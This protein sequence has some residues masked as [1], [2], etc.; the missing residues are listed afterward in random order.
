MERYESAIAAEEAGD[1]V[2]LAEALRRLAILRH[3]RSDSPKARELC[4]R[5][6]E[7]AGKIGNEVLAAEAL[8]TLGGVELSTGALQEARRTFLRALQLGRSS[9]EVRAR[10][11]QNLGILAN[12]QGDLHEALTRY[13]RSLEAYRQCGDEH[14][15]AIAYHNMGSCLAIP[16]SA[17]AQVRGFPKRNAG[18]SRSAA[19]IGSWE[20]SVW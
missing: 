6:Y 9:R 19:A 18:R 17:Y 2:V 11:E 14:G 8:N 16:A 3:H 4:R 10:V 5:S 1:Q 20:R 15:R 12:I 13:E 7:V